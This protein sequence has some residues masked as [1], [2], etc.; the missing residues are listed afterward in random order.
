MSLGTASNSMPVIEIKV[1]QANPAILNPVKVEMKLSGSAPDELGQNQTPGIITVRINDATV[2]TQ[3]AAA[4]TNLVV[5][6]LRVATERN[7]LNQS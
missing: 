7:L 1:R 6:S 5:Q 4:I 2:D 3:L